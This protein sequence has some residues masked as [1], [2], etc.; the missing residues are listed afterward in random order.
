MNS[1]DSKNTRRVSGQRSSTGAQ[2]QRT[3][4]AGQRQRSGSAQRT[5]SAQRSATGGQRQRTASG[6][7]PAAAAAAGQRRAASQ[8]PTNARRPANGQRRQDPRRKKRG[9][10]PILIVLIVIL[11]IAVGSFAGLAMYANQYSNYDKILP[12][13][14]VA[15]IDVGGMTTDEATEAIEAALT[16]TTQQ[17]VTVYLPDQTLTFSPQ[18]DTVLI[19]VDQAVAEAYA[20]G[21]VSS[22][23]FA[24]AR[25]I[26]AAQRTRNDIDIT[27]ALEVDTDYI[28]DMI[29][30]AAAQV[31]TALVESQVVADVDNHM[32]T[33]TIGT[34]GQ[35]LDTEELYELVYS[36]FVNGDYSDI[37]F[38]YD[39]EYPAT[40]QLDTLYEQ[41]S[42]D[43][44]DAIYNTSTGSVDAES[45][46]YSPT[47]DL[48]TA[49]EQL[50]TA[51]AGD[52]LVFTFEEVFPP[53]TA[54][55][56]EANLF[57]DVL[58]SYGTT[59]ASNAGRTTN[60]R[61][62]CEAINGTVIQPGE[63]F[64]FND[65]VGE[66]TAAKGYQEA[67]VYVSGNSVSEV[68]GG[69]CQVASTIYYCAMY[70]DLEI[71]ERTEHM[72]IVDY[73][74]GGLDAT[75]YWGSLDFQFRNSTDY[76][77]QI[78]AYLS[79]G[80]CWIELIGTDVDNYT[81]KIESVKT[82][83]TAFDT[84][85]T[86][87]A[88]AVQSGYTGYTYEITRYVYDSD[89]NLIRTDTTADLDALG[90]LG[91]STYS[92]RDKYV[93][94]ASAA[95]VSDETETSASPSAEASTSPS[96]EASTSPAAETTTSPSAE[97]STSS[98]ADT[99]TDSSS[100]SSTA[101]SRVRS[102]V[103]SGWS[104]TGSSSGSSTDSS[105]GGS[106]ESGEAS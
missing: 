104:S 28:Y 36:A 43:A 10:S 41:M 83:T 33:V 98:S 96:A 89:G 42:S 77:I 92:K 53:V 22:S 94:S 31:E 81:V 95:S 70:A 15:G 57:K 61:L 99:G 4:S 79:G 105:S 67:I 72:Y 12:N 58:Y 62:A 48:D 18:Q 69:I 85:K 87:D 46:G 35:S 27:S 6:Q 103:S 50:A 66:R 11:L 19:D 76:P 39:M 8:R 100:G 71:V 56:L 2:R 82:S 23:P 38:N 90:G 84:I 75:V 30:T 64:S 91:T 102:T 1:Q 32:I 60:L 17:S 26:K 40:I 24:M 9:V 97:T 44:V 34:V 101:S 74:P 106:T 63:V 21:R 14:Y 5:A 86:S 78:N 7:R 68:G 52:V 20:Y 29:E 51:S 88:S 54:E 3:A 65:V 25:A 47:V 93:Y 37:E 73:V 13:V 16:E 59:Y 45:T 55:E 49:N 80:K